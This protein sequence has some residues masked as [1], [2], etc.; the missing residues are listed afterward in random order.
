MRR[1]ALLASLLLAVASPAA[2]EPIAIKAQP[3]GYFSASD[4]GKAVFGP[5]TFRG[6]LVLTSENKE[7]GGISGLRVSADGKLI[8]VTDRGDWLTGELVYEGEKPVAIESADL[9]PMLNANGK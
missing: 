3:I 6:G 8:A 4:P 9:S 1:I 2:S 7:F 5:L